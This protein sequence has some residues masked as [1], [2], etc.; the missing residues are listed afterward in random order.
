MHE[1][2]AHHV[3]QI[4]GFSFNMDTLY[5]TWLAMAVIILIAFIATRNLKLVPTGWQSVIEM[6]MSA[7]LDQIDA[8]MGPKGRK[9]APLIISLFLFILISNWLGL[10]PTLSSPTNDVNTTF[11]LALMVVLMLHVLGVYFKG[12]SYIKHFFQPF[13][14]FIIINIIEEVAKPVT[15]AFRLFGN[16]LAG[17]ILIII[18]LMLVPIWMPI[19]SVVWLAFSVFVGVVQAFIFTMLSM[20]Y[21]ANAVKDDHHD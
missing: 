7:L 1:I 12:M 9:L 11:G 4:A 20:S 6:I 16:I 10:I 19:P 13:A 14:P 15:L 2:G 5:M 21:L 8:T 3:A 18:L 17:E